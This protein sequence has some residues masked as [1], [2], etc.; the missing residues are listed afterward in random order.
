MAGKKRRKKA[1]S[2]SGTDLMRL[3]YEAASDMVLKFFGYMIAKRREA[4]ESEEVLRR[5]RE[6]YEEYARVYRE[7]FETRGVLVSLTEL[8]QQMPDNTWIREM[9]LFVAIKR[10]QYGPPTEAHEEAFQVELEK[11][12]AR[13][14]KGH[15]IQ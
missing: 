9:E 14:N 15:D 5:L 13:K 4:G 1:R 3:S 10:L 8:K 6:D 2:T 12:L 11:R 7:L